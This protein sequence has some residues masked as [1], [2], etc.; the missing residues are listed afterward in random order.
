MAICDSICVRW[1]RI[2]ENVLHKIAWDADWRGS[3][4]FANRHASPLSQ[5]IN[6]Y[7]HASLSNSR[8]VMPLHLTLRHRSP[9]ANVFF[10]L[11]AINSRR[12]IR[13]E[14]G[15][16][17]SGLTGIVQTDSQLS[18]SNSHWKQLSNFLRGYRH[19]RQQ[20][21]ANYMICHLERSNRSS[22]THKSGLKWIP[23]SLTLYPSLHKK[24][25]FFS[26]AISPFMPSHSWL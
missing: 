1:W 18:H 5:G 14:K 19:T 22:G 16:G 23:V 10:E 8:I 20:T 24:E 15:E 12:A 6:P 9:D 7:K 13:R 3:L 21:S 25:T 4:P 11:Y 2:I 26:R 17:R